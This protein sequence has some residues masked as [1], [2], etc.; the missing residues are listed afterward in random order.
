MKLGILGG[1]QLARMIALA[2]HPL[3]VRTLCM[4]PN[5]E[6][7][8][9]DVTEVMTAEFDDA[10]ALQRFLARVDL[11]TY[12]TE[13]I[14][15][16]SA[17]L[18]A[19]SSALYP[20]VE[21]LGIA[22]DRLH[23]KNFFMSLGIPTPPFLSI[24]SEA[25]LVD[26]VANLGLPAVLKTRRMGYDGKGQRVLNTSADIAAAWS[27]LKKSTLILEKFV[28]FEYEVSLISVRNKS[29]KIC[30]YPLVRNQHL[31]GILRSSEAPLNH[32]ELQKQAQHQATKILEALNYIGVLT[33]EFF[34][35]GKQLI[36]NEMAPRV[37]NSGHWTIEGAQTS[38]FE[39]HL[40]AIFNWPLGSPTVT[41]HCFMQNCIGEMPTIESCLSISGAH[42]HTYNKT[43]RP[44]RKVGHITLVEQDF[45]RY[46]QSKQ[47]LSKQAGFSLN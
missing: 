38:Q 4:D 46:V 25:A 44:D 40:R 28:D 12:E 8:A 31:H 32:P 11:V 22:Q 23:E 35:D 7:C 39:N 43:P 26:A 30:F 16:S 9:R 18:V 5:P 37:H 19:Q 47:A 3:G 6:A 17:T 45:T 2:A 27:A 42:Y 33:L 1:G 34:Y 20:S 13:N 29:G 14:P 41:G 21:T 24:D 36:A 10:S 15:L